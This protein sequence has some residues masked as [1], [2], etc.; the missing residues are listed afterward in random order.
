MKFVL[1]GIC[2]QGAIA[3]RLQTLGTFAGGDSLS[4]TGENDIPAGLAT[5]RE[6]Y[7]EVRRHRAREQKLIEQQRDDLLNEK[8][9]LESE[10]I[11]Q[12]QEVDK[13]AC[14]VK[15]AQ[16]INGELSEQLDI[17]KSENDVLSGQ[18][19]SIG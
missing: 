5:V 9:R 4:L 14:E 16:R 13:L 1:V 8:A 19:A 15:S 6:A 18:K 17:K 12:T 7:D 2:K 3:D 10:L 11:G